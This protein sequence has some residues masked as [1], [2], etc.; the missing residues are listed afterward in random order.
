M[1]EANKAVIQR[2]I[3]KGLNKHDISVITEIYAD[4]VYRAPAVGEL[5]SEA[6]RQWVSSVFLAFPDMQFTIQDQFAEGDKVVTRRSFTGTHKGIFMGIAA[7]GKQINVTGM[8][9]NRIVEGKI[10]EEWAEWDTLGMMQQLGA[11]PAAKVK[12]KFAA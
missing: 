7:T 6:F 8:W 9:I 5:R 10:V 11:V 2:L 1:S 4:C 3:E 12:T